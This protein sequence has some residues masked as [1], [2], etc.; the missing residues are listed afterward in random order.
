MAQDEKSR[1]GLG[2]SPL[3]AL[4][5][6]CHGLARDASRHRRMA[7]CQNQDQDGR[8]QEL[9]RAAIRGGA[10]RVEDLI[11]AGAK[12]DARVPVRGD[13]RDMLASGD[14]SGAIVIGPMERSALMGHAD[15]LAGALARGIDPFAHLGDSSDLSGWRALLDEES[16]WRFAAL[17]HHQQMKWLELA[18]S[19]PLSE[20]G[21]EAVSLWLRS[22]AGRERA[23]CFGSQVWICASALMSAL[24]AGL[25]RENEEIGISADSEGMA[26]SALVGAVDLWESA[27]KRRGGIQGAE[28]VLALAERLSKVT[29]KQGWN[30]DQWWAAAARC[31]RGPLAILAI[32]GMGEP[33][34]WIECN[35]LERRGFS[36]SQGGT[37][38]INRW[39]LL[40]ACVCHGSL[41]LACMLESIPSLA[42]A[43]QEGAVESAALVWS[44]MET[45]R[46]ARKLK[47]WGFDLAELDARCLASKWSSEPAVQ[48]AFSRISFDRRGSD[49]ALALGLLAM[50]PEL[51]RMRVSTGQTCEEWLFKEFPECA[52]KA[53]SKIVASAA[54]KPKTS[55]ART[56]KFL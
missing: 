56:S 23:A 3:A 38:L 11:D 8:N 34:A 26:F 42:S 27:A 20:R 37:S 32:S 22:E 2:G 47:D 30:A 51:G 6:A 55:R 17:G 35:A 25:L 44:R 19:T 49:E 13:A 53:E 29:H 40:C 12:F 31:G 45:L 41:E 7:R 9:W 54:G 21:A 15:F 18:C 48:R 10:A 52:A 14:L 39:P 46:Q 16:S 28:Q 5:K 43:L 33:P 50:D 24:E 36:H 4:A 1:S